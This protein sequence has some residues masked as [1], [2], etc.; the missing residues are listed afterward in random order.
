M[1]PKKILLYDTTLRDGV[2]G[3]EISFSL[4]DKLKIV[5][6]LDN[7]GVNYIE[8]G[9]P[10]SNPKDILFFREVRKLSLRNTEI[11]AFGST[12]HKNKNCNNDPNLK[13]IIN[14]KA[15]VAAIFGKSWDFHVKNALG[16]TLDENLAMISETLKWLKSKGMEVIFD[17]EHFFEGFIANKGYALKTLKKAV[18]AGVVNITLCDTNGAMLPDQVGDIVKEVKKLITVPLGIHA[19]NDSDTA[20]ANSI[21]AVQMG[22]ILVQ[23]TI[24]GYGERCGNASL[25]SVIPNLK[26]KL[27]YNCISDKNLKKLTGVC[28]YVDDIANLIPNNKQ[29]FVGH[30][31]FAHKGGV[32]VSAVGK[33]TRTYE[34][35]EPG[36]VGNERRFLISELSGRS[37]IL[38][39]AKEFN[40]SFR[41][42]LESKKL[43]KKVKELE[44]SGYQYEEADGSL[45]LLM[46]KAV[47]KHRTFF[48]LK[49]FRTII[50][51]DQKG[52]LKSEAR[53]KLS[54][55]GKEETMVAEGDGPVNALDTALRSALERF[56]PE[57]KEVNLYDFKV[58]VVNAAKGTKAK[59]RVIIESRDK[60]DTWGTVG[61]SENII[62][63]SWQ[64]LVDS[65]EYKLLKEE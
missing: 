20:V 38:S 48:K 30:S 40:I 8:G 39:K 6:K 52:V 61:V 35:I 2:Q 51:K 64:A 3:E 24:N 63:A 62:E 26:L 58:R 9:W 29:P 44:H 43:L 32:H 55:R 50:S 27:G 59:V 21:A 49:G 16:A 60:K 1:V 13:A 34:H 11:T 65:I 4:E 47:G 57:V 36:L 23:G 28:R 15:K 19:H 45:E 53:V 5:R 10:G 18:E 42:E 56:Y 12:R 14:S 22:C 37:A 41:N 31:A 25:C 17:A 46:K 7:L 33:N 54:V